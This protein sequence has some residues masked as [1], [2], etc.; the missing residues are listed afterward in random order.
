MVRAGPVRETL[1]K[2]PRA[3]CVVRPDDAL[4][5]LLRDTGLVGSVGASGIVA[6]TRGEEYEGQ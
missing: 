6:V 5:I 4:N 1:P 2:S 3:P